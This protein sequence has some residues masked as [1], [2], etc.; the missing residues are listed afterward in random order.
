[1]SDLLNQQNKNRGGIKIFV[2][3][4]LEIGSAFGF[5]FFSQQLLFSPN[6]QN[7]SFFLISLTLFL[8]SGFF[9]ALLIKETFWSSLIFFLA[10]GTALSVF[11]RNFSANLII[12]GL[13]IMWLFLLWGRNRTRAELNDSAKVRFFRL[14]K[15][16]L[17]KTVFGTA[18]FLAFTVYLTTTSK[19]FPVSFPYFQ[20]LL[21]PGEKTLALFMPDFN[22]QNPLQIALTQLAETQLAKTVPDFDELPPLNKNVLIKE[23][24]QEGFLKPIE[25]FAGASVDPT[26]PTDKTIFNILQTKFGQLNDKT[27]TAVT[28]GI[29]VFFFLLLKTCLLPLKWL[30]ALIGYFIYLLLLAFNFID[31]SLEAGSKE[32]IT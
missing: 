11:Y 12:V 3:A 30:S 6:L 10:S 16:F 7:L 28:V 25:V 9:I 29:F 32:V 27:K 5:G 24:V 1:M 2:L 26:E 17:S 18:V 13:V 22:L 23:I 4:V 21:R 19:D 31:V 20:L 15:I 14:T 8:I